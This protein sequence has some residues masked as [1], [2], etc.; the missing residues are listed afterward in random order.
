MRKEAITENVYNA[1]TTP[2]ERETTAQRQ[3][4]A[5]TISREV[6]AEEPNGEDVMPPPNAESISREGTAEE[7]NGEEVM[8]P[9]NAESNS[10]Y[11]TPE[12][13][14]IADATPPRPSAQDEPAEESGSVVFMGETITAPVYNSDVPELYFPVL[15][16]IYLYA[17]LLQRYSSL[18]YADG[19]APEIELEYDKLRLEIR[20]R[21]N[22][23]YDTPW[24]GVTQGY[25]L[26][27]LDSDGTDE[28]I[29]LFD[30]PILMKSRTVQ[31][32]FTIR[33]GNLVCVE[34]GKGI[35]L[36]DCILASGGTFYQCIDWRGAGFADLNAFRLEEG[37][38]ELTTVSEAHAALSF[39][40]GDIPVPYWT[41]TENGG[42]IT[43]TEEEFNVLLE[44]YKNPKERME[45]N[46]TAL[47]SDEY[48][49]LS[50]KEPEG[51]TPPVP[52][53]SYPEFYRDA[54]AE[55]KPVLDALFLLRDNMSRGKERDG[56]DLEAVEFIRYPYYSTVGFLPEGWMLSYALADLNC[57]GVLELLLGS[58]EALEKS[59]PS[60]IFTIKDGHS[61]H[62]TSFYDRCH[63]IIAADRTIYFVEF[64][65]AAYISLNTYVLD[66]DG[67]SLT[68]LTNIFSDLFRD[69]S[70]PEDYYPYFVQVV[71]G[72]NRYISEEE[73]SE[74]ADIYRNPPER[75][76]LTV[77]PISG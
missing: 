55:Y 59:E 43:I 37:K 70:N 41:K 77:I 3:P 50:A 76:K 16:D 63:G 64:A 72:K 45:L 24:I 65:G 71:D 34:D 9:P 40:S 8:P 31:G 58:A 6:T 21:G 11:I 57:D 14:H 75:L 15:D 13:P 5:E 74:Y 62:V 39:E 25:C 12:E 51:E 47:Y 29:I 52:A 17:M 23:P 42:E 38:T 18:N 56:K 68:R 33:N 19:I 44:K 22:L 54:P 60:S 1:E 27:D 28:L 61:V 2:R 7:P 26:V 48:A 32:I 10:Q 73:F 35:E 46:F 30:D 67:E 36:R 49:R 53:V 4:E 66:G 69:D 20:E